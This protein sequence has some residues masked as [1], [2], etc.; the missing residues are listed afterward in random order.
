MPD[1]LFRS[2][3]VAIAW[4]AGVLLAAS[5]FLNGGG[6]DMLDKAASGLRARK[7]AVETPAQAPPVVIP[8]P[9]PRVIIREVD[10]PEELARYRDMADAQAEDRRRD[11]PAGPDEDFGDSY[12][13][14]DRAAAVEDATAEDLRA[15]AEE[16]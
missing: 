14:V 11:D 8:A 6:R 2:R 3:S 16:R 5:A 1:F 10:D 7:S 9:P 4:A 13:V 15:N 12:V